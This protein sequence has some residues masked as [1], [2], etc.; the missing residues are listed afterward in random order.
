MDHQANEI[1]ELGDPAVQQEK[2][3]SAAGSFGEDQLGSMTKWE[4][5][6]RTG[7]TSSPRNYD[8]A[9]P[10]D[11]DAGS[12][13][14][15]VTY[16]L[17][18]VRS[19]L[20]ERERERERSFRARTSSCTIFR[21]PPTLCGINPKA[22]QP[23]IVSIGP[24]HRGREN[25]L[26]FEQHKWTFLKRFLHRTPLNVESLVIS[27]ARAESTARGCFSELVLMSSDHFVEMMLLDSCFA[28]GTP[29]PHFQERGCD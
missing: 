13:N 9:G 15:A 1:E 7:L 23:E 16:C 14:E 18:R 29:T 26:E 24:Y 2:I 27:V 25:L 4:Q 19:R 5:F 22:E 17:A 10:V 20:G 21:I 11:A 3:R 28:V 12:H 6:R 8:V